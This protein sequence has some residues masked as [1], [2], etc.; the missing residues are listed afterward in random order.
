M[1]NEKYNSQKIREILSE[2][3][4]CT[5]LSCT[6]DGKVYSSSAEEYLEWLG[7]FTKYCIPEMK[8]DWMDTIRKIIYG[9]LVI[10]PKFDD[11]PDIQEVIRNNEYAIIDHLYDFMNAAEIMK[12][13]DETH[14]WDSVNE[15][16]REQ[17]HSGWTFSGLSNIMIKY[18]LIGVDFIEKFD[19]DRI[20][21]D[22]NF[23]EY[24]N[25]AKEYLVAR[26]TL[27]KKLILAISSQ[28]RI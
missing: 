14:S 5:L 17:G 23:R 8:N 13:Y 28:N 19:S 27:N 2:I 20:S 26:Q 7:E 4:V 25:K 12:V 22:K 15:V 16:L 24:Y 11:D 9:V 6:N 1:T 3:R 18:S 10:K 21:R